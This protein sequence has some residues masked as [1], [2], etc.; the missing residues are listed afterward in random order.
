MA[1]AEVGRQARGQL[2][3]HR[4]LG[5][6]SFITEGN[7]NKSDDPCSQGNPFGPKNGQ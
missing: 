4:E 7:V 1:E 5:I 6:K 3:T 2:E